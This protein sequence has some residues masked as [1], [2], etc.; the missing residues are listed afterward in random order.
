MLFSMIVSDFPIESKLISLISAIENIWNLQAWWGKS[1]QNVALPHINERKD[2]A[3]ISACLPP[4][5]YIQ[6]S[7]PSVLCL[8]NTSLWGPITDKQCLNEEYNAIY[9]KLP[10]LELIMG[11]GRTAGL[12]VFLMR[13]SILMKINPLFGPFVGQEGCEGRLTA[14]TRL[15]DT[16]NLRIGWICFK[17]SSIPS[18]IN[19]KLHL[20]KSLS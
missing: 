18:K 16:P 14:S 1:L 10:K 5:F 15:W 4:I 3:N 17:D 12:F 6:V 8:P 9:I 19:A 7:K 2:V 13:G 20:A 11:I